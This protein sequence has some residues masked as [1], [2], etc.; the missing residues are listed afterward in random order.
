M[1]YKVQGKERIKPAGH[2]LAFTPRF[3]HIQ[4]PLYPTKKLCGSSCKFQGRMKGNKGRVKALEQEGSQ[5]RLMTGTNYGVYQETHSCP[6]VRQI[7]YCPVA[8]NLKA[9]IGEHT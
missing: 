1:S 3:S 8:H 2:P 4:I 9:E 6:L 5:S 7:N